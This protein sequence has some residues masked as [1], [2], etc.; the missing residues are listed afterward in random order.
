MIKLQVLFLIL[1]LNLLIF[2]Y[3]QRIAEII[4]VYDYPLKKRKIHKI[5][6]P[7]IGGIFLLINLIFLNILYFIFNDFYFNDLNKIFRGINKYFVFLFSSLIIFLI[8]YFDDKK[9]L[10]AN[11]K[12]FLFII[13]T[14]LSVYLDQNLLLQIIVIKSMDNTINLFKFSF[15]FYSP[16]LFTFC[17]CSQHVR[18]Y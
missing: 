8:G 12:F 7:L 9:N 14:A 13:I 2:K 1:F 5:K 11:L 18:W 3:Y 15:F 6:T 10:N 4:N 17:K 16:V